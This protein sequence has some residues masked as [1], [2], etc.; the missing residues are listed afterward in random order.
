MASAFIPCVLLLSS[1]FLGEFISH[2]TEV[3]F[4]R[5]SIKFVQIIRRLRTQILLCMCWVFV[6][7]QCTLK[8]IGILWHSLIHPGVLS[9]KVWEVLAKAGLSKLDVALL[10]LGTFVLWLT[11]Y[12]RYQG[13]TVYI[14]LDK[15]PLYI[16]VLAVYGLIL[17]IM[18]FGK[19]GASSF[20]YFQ[21]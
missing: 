12:I 21:F 15:R 2:R 20:I 7:A 6:N 14:E 19:F 3:H 13:S 11:D 1:D 10:L 9:F 17:F 16:R 8:G 5:V 18:L 4:S